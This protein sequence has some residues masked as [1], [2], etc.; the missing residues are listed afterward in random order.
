MP[1]KFAW[2]ERKFDFAFPVTKYPDIVERLRGTPARLEERIGSLPPEILTLQEGESWS[3]Q[4]NVGHLVDVEQ[5]WIGRIDDILGGQETMRPADV[6]NR[7]TCEADHDAVEIGLLTASFR[8][9]R[10][11]LVTRLDGLDEEAFGTACQHPRLQK[12][13]RLVDLCLFAA[14]HDD[15][16]LARITE[17]A[18]I[19]PR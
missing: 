10:T 2:F 5:L 16:H 4:R 11:R 6:T 3:I 9:A 17:L 19:L 12:P 8:Q 14:E 7:R 15:Y 1:A 13:M 18:R